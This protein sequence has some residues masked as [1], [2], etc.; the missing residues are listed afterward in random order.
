[1]DFEDQKLTCTS[2]MVWKATLSDYPDT[3]RS[4]VYR[5]GD[6]IL[7][8]FLQLSQAKYTSI[9]IISVKC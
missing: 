4:N 3:D 1:M 8:Q 7:H 9:R 6:V 2:C 5:D